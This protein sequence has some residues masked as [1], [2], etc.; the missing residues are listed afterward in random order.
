MN[1]VDLILFLGIFWVARTGWQNGLIQSLLGLLSLLVAYAVALAYGGPAAAWFS[2]TA[3]D[4]EGGAAL[5]GFLAVFAL[6][7]AGCYLLGRIVRTFLQATPL[8]IVDILAGG[9]F[10]LAKGV[11]IFGLL[12][13]FCRAYPI[14]SRLSGLIDESALGTPVQQAALYLADAVQTQFPRAKDLLIKMGIQADDNPPPI[15]EKLNKEAEKAKE[16][17]NSFIDESRKR[18]ES[19]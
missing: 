7:L 14:H 6:A 15:V 3:E 1:F 5:L 19:K 8:G 2:D 16:K 17:L 9:A 11:F 12:T 10:G 4:I 13:V 18:L